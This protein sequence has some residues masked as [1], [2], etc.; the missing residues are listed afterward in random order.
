MGF[1]FLDSPG[2]V[3]GTMVMLGLFFGV[4]C[5]AVT[6]FVLALLK[7]IRLER[8]AGGLP[9]VRRVKWLVLLVLLLVLAAAL[10]TGIIWLMY[11]L[12]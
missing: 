6:G 7:Y 8:E 5:G 12:P 4:P 1:P 11:S 2:I 3:T 9:A 10:M